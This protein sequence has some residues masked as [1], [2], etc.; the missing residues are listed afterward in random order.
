MPDL[1][2]VPDLAHLVA[3]EQRRA[4]LFATVS[5]AHLYGFPS[6]DSDIDVRGVHLSPLR[7]VLGLTPAPET[8]T[9]VGD[10]D[11]LEMDLVTE[12]EPRELGQVVAPTA[13]SWNSFSPRSWCA[14]PANTAP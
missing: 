7:D 2:D 14:R 3:A 4:L 12:R 8:R 10:A 13:V 5:D 11:G 1:P 6:R 9:R